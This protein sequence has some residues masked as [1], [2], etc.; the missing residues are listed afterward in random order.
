M[1]V[2]VHT[3]SVQLLCAE[4]V[5]LGSKEVASL[6]QFFMQFIAVAIGSEG[7]LELHY[8]SGT[9]QSKKIYF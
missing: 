4:R 1:K 2:F 9:S 7:M 8:D 5:D 6:L 3:N